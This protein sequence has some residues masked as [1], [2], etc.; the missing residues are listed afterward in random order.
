MT[1]TNRTDTIAKASDNSISNLGK[2]AKNLWWHFKKK[3]SKI[4]LLSG[5]DI[6]ILSTSTMDHKLFFLSKKM[7]NWKRY[8]WKIKDW[9]EHR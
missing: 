1:S 2:I 4:F 7:L 5:K 3:A 6:T 9:D 8:V